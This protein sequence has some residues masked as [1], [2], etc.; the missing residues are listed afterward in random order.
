MNNYNFDELINRKNTNSIKW[1][2]AAK[3]GKPE[4][5]FP[6]WVADMDFK[7]PKEV[8]DALVEKAKHGIFGYSEPGETY[9]KVLN[10]W[11]KQHYNWDLD[12]SKIII[13]PGVVFS[14]CSL[15]RVLTDEN[16][17]I[18]ISE[19]VYYP[20]KESIIS[21]YR[22][23]I[24]NELML[25]N[26][27]YYIDFNDFEEKIIE[28]N[29][30]MYILCNPHNPVGRAWTYEE[31]SKIHEICVRHNVYVVSDEIHADF[32]YSNNHISY[33]LLDEKACIC[34]APTKTFNIPGLQ[35]ANTY[36]PNEN[37][38][39]LFRN[40]LNKIGYS[41][42]SIMGIIACEAAYQYGEKWL[43]ELKKYLADN[44][45]FVDKYIKEKLPKV[46]LIYPE[47]TY[48]VWLDFSGIGLD[49]IEINNKII[50]GAKLWLDEGRIFG[51]SGKY[52]QR[53]NIAT[54]RKNLEYALNRLYN[55]FKD[56]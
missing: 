9:F 10:N 44:I 12:T 40:D 5:I 20:F 33:H 7:V 41:Q 39:S 18:M 17:G 46:K 22:K 6:L 42:V 34:T 25:L 13:T 15:I 51:H 55:E 1:D 28:N 27:K 26:G 16:D 8:T 30:K 35:I 24:V 31:L 14:L 52:F 45:D 3:R 49:D 38:I 50:N 48:L 29:V 2:D 19:P 54:S 43:S 11:F 37:H 23:P 53:I 56:N 36:I 47:A 32:V 4:D 21:N